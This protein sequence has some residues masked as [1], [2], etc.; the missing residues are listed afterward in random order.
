M[1][2]IHIFNQSP[3]SADFEERV[4]ELELEE[5]INNMFK[6][7]MGKDKPSQITEKEVVEMISDFEVSD[8]KMMKILRKMREIFG[9][10]AVTPNIR[11]AIIARKKKVLKYFKVENTT[12]KDKDGNDI[13]RQFVFTE[14]LE[15]LLDFVISERDYEEDNVDVKVS[16]DGGQGRMLVVLHLD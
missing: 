11:E 9:K 6:R 12:F 8:R 4:K 13:N 15:L 5:E 2:Q 3:L 7:D 14:D 1:I 10:K 16:M